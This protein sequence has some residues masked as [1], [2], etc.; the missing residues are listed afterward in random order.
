MRSLYF[1]KFSPTL[2]AELADLSM[3][4]LCMFNRFCLSASSAALAAFFVSAFFAFFFCS[5]VETGNGAVD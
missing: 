1:V 5:L 2:H 3:A 4:L